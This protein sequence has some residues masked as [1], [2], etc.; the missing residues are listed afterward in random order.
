MGG[1]FLYRYVAGHVRNFR[2]RVR[3][4]FTIFR[5]PRRYLTRVAVPQLIGWFLR[6]A[7]AYQMLVAFGIEA[8]VRN[9]L[10]VL[11]VG[12]ISTL[13]PLT[14]GGRRHAAGPDRA[15]AGRHRSR[16][17]ACSPSRSE[18]RSRSRSRT[19]WS[20]WSRWR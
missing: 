2:E 17:A 1:F 9:A 12:A 16:A 14:P 15:R 19:A 7:S 4:G 11:V 8:S 5:T 10:L 13:L 6:V 18:P 3:Q 20:G